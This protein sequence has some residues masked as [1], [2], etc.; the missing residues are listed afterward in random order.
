ME[1]L[2][3]TS[4]GLLKVA[5][6]RDQ[7]AQGLAQASFANLQGWRFHI[8][9]GQAVPVCEIIG[10][11]SHTSKKRPNSQLFSFIYNYVF[12]YFFP[13]LMKKGNVADNC[14][15]DMIRVNS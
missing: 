7:V 13:A 15:H 5:S 3:G 2:E 8:L 4:E 11:L 10:F 6:K 9:S 1:E 12:D 14:N